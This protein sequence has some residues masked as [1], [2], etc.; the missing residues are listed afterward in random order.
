[1]CL[2]QKQEAKQGDPPFPPHKIIG[3]IYYVGSLNS[4]SYL[5]TTPQGH[6]VINSGYQF[7]VPRIKA[8]MEG[9]GFKMKDVKFLLTS[10]GH[11]DHIA[12]CDPFIKE[13]GASLYVMTGDAE[14]VSNGGHGDFAYKMYFE[15]CKVSREL[16]DGDT[17]TL[18]GVTLTARH[19]PGHTRGA[20][21]FLMNVTEGG[22][23]YKVVF[24]ASPKVN[25]TYRLVDNIRY[26]QIAS[27]YRRTFAI[28]KS[29]ECDVFLGAHGSDYNMQEKFRRIGKGANPF[30]DPQGYRTYVAEQQKLFEG[31]LAAQVQG[32]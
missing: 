24:A 1:M 16:K 22:K 31:A 14:V 9:L 18:G 8:N 29:L 4:A 10:E 19:T 25:P 26:P 13:S 27:D 11:A 20:T 23:T 5:I 2:A 21:T 7:L 12:G 15:P 30:I 6:M 17:I 3:N 28:L 32:R